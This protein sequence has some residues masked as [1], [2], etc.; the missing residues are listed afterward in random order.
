M[1]RSCKKDHETQCSYELPWLAILHAY[2]H[3][4]LLGKHCWRG[5]LEVLALEPSWTLPV[6]LFSWQILI[7]IFSI[8]QTITFS[9]MVSSEFYGSFSMNSWSRGWSWILCSHRVYKLIGI[10]ILVLQMG[11]GSTEMLRELLIVIQ[12]VPVVP[13]STALSQMGV[14]LMYQC[15][16]KLSQWFQSTGKF[17]DTWAGNC[18]LDD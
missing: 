10:S 13:T 9:I 6:H 2:C 18:A 5:L 4:L 14:V 12:P 16:L 17:E 15:I 11:D 3:M 8:Q 1:W 7:F